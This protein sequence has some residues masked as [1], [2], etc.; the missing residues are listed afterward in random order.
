MQEN[1][2][3]EHA[4]AR[5]REIKKWRREKKLTLIKTLNPEFK[6]LNDEVAD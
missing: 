3:I 6:F 2:I 5:E 4:I 1:I